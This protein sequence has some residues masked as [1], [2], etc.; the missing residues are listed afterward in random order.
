MELFKWLYKMQQYIMTL[1]LFVPREKQKHAS[2]F[3]GQIC[4][5][6]L[7]KIDAL[8][9]ILQ[10]FQLE[11]FILKKTETHSSCLNNESSMVRKHLG[12]L[13]RQRQKRIP[14]I[15]IMVQLAMIQM[16]LDPRQL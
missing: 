12:Q 8:D 6:L 11:S 3:Q 4:I 14:R 9:K 2:D 13:K 10:M 1:M 5:S 16:E 15:E 7:T